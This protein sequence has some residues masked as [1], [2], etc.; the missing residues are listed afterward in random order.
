MCTANCAGGDPEAAIGWDE[1][2][3]RLLQK[4]HPL[5]GAE[6]L[7]TKV[8]D[9]AIEE[10]IAKLKASEAADD[11]AERKNGDDDGEEI[12]ANSSKNFTWQ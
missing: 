4:N 9:T 10:Q 3:Q 8:E 6:I 12:S 11:G 1:A 2:G 5:G 7:F